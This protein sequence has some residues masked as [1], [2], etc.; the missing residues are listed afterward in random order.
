MHHL[1]NGIVGIIYTLDSGI[2]I[3]KVGLLQSFPVS[4]YIMQSLRRV[5][6]NEIGCYADMRAI[7]LVKR[8]QPYMAIASQPMIKLDPWG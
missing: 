5:D 4:V 3:V 7:L 8:M 1:V 6:G 2:R